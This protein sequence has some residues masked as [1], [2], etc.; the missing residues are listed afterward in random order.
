MQEGDASGVSRSGKKAIEAG[1]GAAQKV[2]IPD[3]VML[4]FAND[5]GI[6]RQKPGAEPE[7][8]IGASPEL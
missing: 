4:D 5:E 2:F 3:Y 8:D 1:S 7:T 6:T